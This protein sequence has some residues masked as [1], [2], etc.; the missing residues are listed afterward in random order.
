MQLVIHRP[1]HYALRA[2]GFTPCWSRLLRQRAKAS[3][4]FPSIKCSLDPK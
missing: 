1:G 3:E 4:L 2:L